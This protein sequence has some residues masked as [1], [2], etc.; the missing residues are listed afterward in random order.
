[1]AA[2]GGPPT[3][4]TEAPGAD[5][6]PFYSPDG[7]RIAFHSDRDGRP[8]VWV[9]NA[10]GSGQRKLTSIGVG[11]HFMR[12]SADG[13]W[14]I[15]R[16]EP[17]GRIQIHRVSVETGRLERLPD[18]ASGGHMSFSPDRSRIMDVRDHKVLWVYPL[19]GDAPQRVFEF[20]NPEI[21]I[22]YT[23]WSPD[24]RSVLFDRATLRGGD[25]WTLEGLR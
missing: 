16:A 1:M 24:G 10:D 7:T 19:R 8:E 17:A 4:L 12:W 13:R 2:G 9:M 11:G 18:V 6:N 22:D 3:R 15:C 20:P 25:I 23:V 5:I 14:V 21:R